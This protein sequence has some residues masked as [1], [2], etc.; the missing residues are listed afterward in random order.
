MRRERTDTLVGLEQALQIEE[1]ALD[2][3]LMTQPDAY[4]RV[5][6]QVAL[7][8]SLR[9]EAKQALQ[10]I[11]ARIDLGVRREA[12]DNEDRVTEKEVEAR[13]RVH[14]DVIAARNTLNDLESHLL[15]CVALKEAFQQ[16]SYMLREMVQLHISRHYSG[17]EETPR[18]RYLDKQADEVRRE[19]NQMRRRR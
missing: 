16:R 4:Y 6:R 15:E 5:S 17:T 14:R 8:T 11:E 3:A 10:E 1:H 19:A 2:E 7:T 18:N 9:D 12:Y 13:K